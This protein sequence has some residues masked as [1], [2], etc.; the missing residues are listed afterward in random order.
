[1]SKLAT[2]DTSF[3]PDVPSQPGPLNDYRKKAKFDWKLLRIYFEGEDC[4]K[5]KYEVWNRI[6]QDPLF[7]RPSITVSVDEQKKLAATRMKRVIDLKLLPKEIKNASYLTRVNRKN[8][9]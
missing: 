6:Q 8:K 1:M 7:D 5:A 9:R 2:V 4:L 3:I